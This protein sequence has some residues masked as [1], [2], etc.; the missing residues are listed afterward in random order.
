MNGGLT[1]AKWDSSRRMR[2]REV[3]QIEK[4]NRL[5]SETDSETHLTEP[6]SSRP[7]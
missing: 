1:R 2:E 5:K 3:K 6:H 4:W 7:I